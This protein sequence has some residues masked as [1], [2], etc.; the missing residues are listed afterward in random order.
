MIF[1]K[2]FDFF[3]TLFSSQPKQCATEFFY[4]ISHHKLGK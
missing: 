3:P 2:N 4:F 1:F